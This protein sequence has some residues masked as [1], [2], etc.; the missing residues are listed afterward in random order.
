VAVAA[1]L[2]AVEVDLDE[3]RCGFKW[4]ARPYPRR[5]SSG[6]PNQDDVG[7]QGLFASGEEIRCSGGSE[8]RLAVVDRE[9]ELLDERS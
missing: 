3:L 5:K 4:L 9:T 8:P 2:A 6:V 7:A 1:D